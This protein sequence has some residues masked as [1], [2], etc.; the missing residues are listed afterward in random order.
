MLKELVQS[1]TR[2]AKLKNYYNQQ[3]QQL[4]IIL[5]TLLDAIVLYT[6]G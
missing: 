6:A 4:L 1:K 3:V 2:F 5:I